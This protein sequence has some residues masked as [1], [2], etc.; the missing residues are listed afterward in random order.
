MV[1]T[2]ALRYLKYVKHSKVPIKFSFTSF[3]YLPDLYSSFSLRLSCNF[4]LT[5]FVQNMC[6]R[7]TVEIQTASSH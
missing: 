4:Q 1:G 7:I 2:V 6:L 5:T 3:E